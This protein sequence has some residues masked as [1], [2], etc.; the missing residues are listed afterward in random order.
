LAV[1]GAGGAAEVAPGAAGGKPG[2]AFAASPQLAGRAVL[3]EPQMVEN[4]VVG[5]GRG[6]AVAR[7][8]EIDAAA[9]PKG[10]RTKARPSSSTA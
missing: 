2:L 7:A 8:D 3:D 6:M 10:I 9:G 1:R 5:V 4:E